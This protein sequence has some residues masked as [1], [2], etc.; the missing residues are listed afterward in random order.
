MKRRRIHWTTPR[1][2]AARPDGPLVLRELLSG[3]L[4]LGCL[5]AII[6]FILGGRASHRGRPPRGIGTRY[7]DPTD[8]PIPAAALGGYALGTAIVIT[9]ANAD[10]QTGIMIG[11]V[12]AVFLAFRGTPERITIAAL[13]V[14]AFGCALIQMTH[15]VR[16][17]PYDA[18]ASGYRLAEQ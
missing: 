8:S 13:D 1:S 7:L 5:I 2:D 16:G 6:K 11:A 18:L 4:V 10:D 3:L 17:D 9:D 15:I 12:V 14:V